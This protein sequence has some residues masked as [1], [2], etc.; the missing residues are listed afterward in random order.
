MGELHTPQVLL[1]LYSKCM[2]TGPSYIPPT[3]H[4]LWYVVEVGPVDQEVRHDL[5]DCH[6]KV[7]SS[8][9]E[10]GKE[11]K[12]ELHQ[13]DGGQVL[14]RLF[15]DSSVVD[16]GVQLFC[17]YLKLKTA[18]RGKSHTLYAYAST[19]AQLSLVA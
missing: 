13:W 8:Q 2:L 16:Q 17:A 4:K 10:E 14:G 3:V 11:G 6:G 9:D 18:D 12:P 1:V 19:L 5:H 15:G 7:D